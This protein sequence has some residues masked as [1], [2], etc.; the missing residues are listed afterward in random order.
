MSLRHHII[1]NN[2]PV[3]LY[4]SVSEELADQIR[5]DIAKAIDLLERSRLYTDAPRA[6]FDDID[7]AIQFL[8]ERY[9]AVT[10]SYHLSPR[11]Q[12][13]A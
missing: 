9:E 7:D 1:V 2:A 8:I 11:E 10:P 12:A 6:F 3:A 4:P 13:N 5:D